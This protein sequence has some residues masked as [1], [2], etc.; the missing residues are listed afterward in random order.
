MK[1]GLFLHSRWRVVLRQ[2]IIQ[3][4]ANPLLIFSKF[5]MKV[6]KHFNTF[7]QCSKETSNRLNSWALSCCCW[8]KFTVISKNEWSFFIQFCLISFILSKRNL[9]FI[10]ITNLKLLFLFDAGLF[11]FEI[12]NFQYL[13]YLATYP[14]K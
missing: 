13:C 14:S 5:W 3:S 8:Q 12:A 7:R 1:M 11:E 2:K 4:L 9:S 10:P 6:Q